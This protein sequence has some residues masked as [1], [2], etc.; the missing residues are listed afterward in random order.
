MTEKVLFLA[1]YDSQLKVARY[2]SEEFKRQG[3]QCSLRITRQERNQFSSRQYGEYT[4][5]LSYECCDYSVEDV[6]RGVDGYSVIVVVLQGYFVQR[7][8]Y[9]FFKLHQSN[10]SRPIWITGFVGVNLF[11]TSLGYQRR[12]NSDLV[13]MNSQKDVDDCE[14][15][16]TA[17]GLPGGHAIASGLPYVKSIDPDR[18]RSR[19]I[20]QVVFAGQPD[21]P[22]GLVD[23]VYILSK[24]ME[25]ARAF[26]ERKVLLKP[27]HRPSEKSLHKTVHH[28]EIILRSYFSGVDI[29]DNFSITYESIPSLLDDSQLFITVSSTAA[30]EALSYNTQVVILKDFGISELSGT[31]YF[32]DSGMMCSFSDLMC[33]R[34][35][36]VSKAWLSYSV[37]SGGNGAKFLCDKILSVSNTRLLHGLDPGYN[38]EFEVY[39]ESKKAVDYVKKN[40]VKKVFKTGYYFFNKYI[41]S[42]IRWV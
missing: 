35:G 32:M 29:P 7:L 39:Q 36:K 15:V 10:R 23:R 19:D 40:Y 42:M 25:Y 37:G 31:S 16:A 4:G 21:V 17:I 24:M 41:Y 6:L 14:K 1:S 3:W 18:E 11:N 33:D 20:R 30:I 38:D 27:R 2:F 9:E 28:Y 34:F 8:S 26:P 12:L 5:D 13:F 22:S